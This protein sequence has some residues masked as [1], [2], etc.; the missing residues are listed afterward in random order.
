MNTK[1]MNK[2]TPTAALIHRADKLY[3]L[4]AEMRVRASDHAGNGDYESKE[5]AT[6]ATHRLER[7]ALSL[8]L[9]LLPSKAAIRVLN[10]R[11]ECS[12]ATCAR[13]VR[14]AEKHGFKYLLA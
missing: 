7:E 14:R 6:K 4:A 3:C 8:L 11:L 2:K 1:T 12:E 13:A 10:L 9:S 5:R